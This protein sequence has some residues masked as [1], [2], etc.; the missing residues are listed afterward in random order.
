MKPGVCPCAG[1]SGMEMRKDSRGGKHA[2]RTL[3][4]LAET[5]EK[6]KAQS[7]TRRIALLYRRCLKL[8]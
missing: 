6:G 1:V 8:C 3:G 4:N 7:D 5:N 2:G